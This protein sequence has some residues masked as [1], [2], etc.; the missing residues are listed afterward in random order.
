MQQLPQGPVSRKEVHSS[1]SPQSFPLAPVPPHRGLDPLPG[2]R[3]DFSPP[4]SWMEIERDLQGRSWLESL[5]WDALCLE[6]E[7]F[8][9]ASEESSQSEG[10]CE[11]SGWVSALLHH[12]WCSPSFS[13]GTVSVWHHS[14]LQAPHLPPGH[15]MPLR[16]IFF[17]Q[18]LAAD[19]P[20][21]CSVTS[22]VP[23]QLSSAPY[24]VLTSSLL[25][26]ACTHQRS[27]TCRQQNSG[28]SNGVCTWVAEG[29][30]RG[31]VC[32]HH[33][34][35]PC[36]NSPHPVATSL[37]FRIIRFPCLLEELGFLQGVGDAGPMLTC[38]AGG[39]AAGFGLHRAP[40]SLFSPSMF[41]V[42]PSACDWRC[43]EAKQP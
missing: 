7:L 24:P 9:S 31:T 6:T 35:R 43:R 34:H 15:P 17:A 8:T 18:D 32:C 41:E 14:Y 25:P 10:C 2:A 21:L 13:M 16:I 29:T 5:G 42:I 12:K 26:V 20:D 33:Q 11:E 37:H 23:L 30:A 27:Q 36:L 38:A 1:D 28:A 22:L 39:T 3:G 4:W 40:V 19:F